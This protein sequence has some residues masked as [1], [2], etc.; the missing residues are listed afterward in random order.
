MNRNYVSLEFI[1]FLEKNNIKFLSR[2]KTKCFVREREN[3]KSD[4]EIVELAHTEKRM[5]KYRFRNEEIREYLKER[6]STR[7]RILKHKLKTGEEEYLITNI[8]DLSH[9]ELIEV[10]G[11]R[12]N[13]ETTYFSL[14]SKLQIEKFTSSKEIIIKQDLYAGMLVYNMV[15]TMKNEA[16]ED[17]DQSKYKHEMTVNENVSIGLF[18]KEMIHLMLEEDDE[19]M[20]ERYDKLCEKILEYKVPIRKDRKYDVQRRADNKN[21]FNKLKSF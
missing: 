13:I 8:E 7:V 19:K 21:S 4:D 20:L 9:E 3:M 12:W 5:R 2:L 18:K 16:R 15:Q 11:K 1:G 17:I 6:E 14:K 10:Y